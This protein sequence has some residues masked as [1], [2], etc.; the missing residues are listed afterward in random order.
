MCFSSLPAAFLS[1]NIISCSFF[2]FR[3]VC[4]YLGEVL[5]HVPSWAQ[6]GHHGSIWPQIWGENGE[7]VWMSR[8]TNKQNQCLSKNDLQKAPCIRCRLWCFRPIGICT[9]CEHIWIALWSVPSESW[10]H[11]SSVNYRWFCWWFLWT[12]FPGE[13]K[14]WKVQWSV[15]RKF[16]PSL[17]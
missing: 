17:L 8:P 3:L 16:R 1:S 11:D 9:E 15:T 12:E 2:S 6:E 5:L 7:Q 14:H 4:V 10:T 13:A